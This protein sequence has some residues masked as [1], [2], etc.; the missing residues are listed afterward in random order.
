MCT[1]IVEGEKKNWPWEREVRSCR[2]HRGQHPTIVSRR[3]VQKS[4]STLGRIF[5][6]RNW[7]REYPSSGSLLWLSQQPRWNL[8]RPV[9]RWNLSGN[10]KEQI[11]MDQSEPNDQRCSFLVVREVR[12]NGTNDAINSITFRFFFRWN[13]HNRSLLHLFVNNSVSRHGGCSCD[14]RRLDFCPF[15]SAQFL[16]LFNTF[17]GITRGNSR[18]TSWLLLRNDK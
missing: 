9:P 10:L 3:Y 12:C 15:P 7:S 2:L 17:E 8:P 14:L 6:L 16:F 1:T 4:S 5:P 11:Q 18:T 13:A